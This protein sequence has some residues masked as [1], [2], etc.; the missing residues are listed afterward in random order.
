MSHIKLIN[1]LRECPASDFFGM[2]EADFNEGTMSVTKA[3]INAIKMV[4]KAQMSL[5]DSIQEEEK[6]SNFSS[7]NQSG[8][9]FRGEHPQVHIIESD[10]DDIRVEGQQNACE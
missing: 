1:V 10:G 5:I 3:R 8:P 9:S 2:S 6:S 4:W 7:S